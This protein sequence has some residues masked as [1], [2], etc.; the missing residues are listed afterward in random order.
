MSAILAVDSI[1]YF[2]VFQ[3]AYDLYLEFPT[4]PVVNQVFLMT[5][6]SMI[7]PFLII[8]SIIIFRRNSKTISIDGEFIYFKNKS[9]LKGWQTKVIN[10]SKVHLISERKQIA[11]TYTGKTL[12]PIIYYW[13]VFNYQNGN[14]DEASIFGWDNET[15]KNIF[16]LLRTKFPKIKINT[17]LFRD[18]SADL[19]GVTE[20][21]QK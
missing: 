12:I 3:K 8:I 16:F 6:I 7:L 13:L 4:D 21:L 17:Y 11:Y 10:L 9:I 18:S 19:S 1:L 20:F 2:F 5:T 15:L 14:K